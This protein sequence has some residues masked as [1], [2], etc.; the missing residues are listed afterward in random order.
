M[1]QQAAAESAQQVQQHEQWLQ[2]QQ[3]MVKGQQRCETCYTMVCS[4][5]KQKQSQNQQRHMLCTSM[6]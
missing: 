3:G 6:W 4:S 1:Q 5:R 2:L